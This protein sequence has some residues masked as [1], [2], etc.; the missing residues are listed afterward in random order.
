MQAVMRLGESFLSAQRYLDDLG[1]HAETKRH[2]AAA[3][4]AGH[5]DIA[6]DPRMAIGKKVAVAGRHHRR[7]AEQADLAAMGMTG[8]LQRHARRHAHGNVGLMRKQDDRRVVGDPGK[9]R[10]EIVHANATDGAE[11]SRREV[12]KLVA[13][14]GE[15]EVTTI[16]GETR[17]IILV[18]RDA[19][20][21]QRA[22]RDCRAPPVQL[23]CPILPII[24][25][26]QDRVHAQRRLQAGKNGRPIIGRNTTRHMPVSRDV[27]SK[28]HD[29]IR[30]KRV[31]AFDDRIDVVERHPGIA[32]MEVGDNGDPELE[33]RRPARRRD[34]VARDIEPKDRLAEAIGRARDAGGTDPGHGAKK[35]AA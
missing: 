7:P 22:A 34:L 24:M 16:L 29:D 9:R 10:V 8:Q 35:L 30:P 5:D 17:G 12:G 26:A 11:I 6:I 31:G 21:F 15:P 2:D 19:R 33:I 1:R 27:I 23:D 3:E 32:G 4:P 14:A 20:C 13:E 28:H 25:V 18:D